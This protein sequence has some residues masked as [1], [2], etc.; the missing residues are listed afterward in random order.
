MLHG[1]T[2]AHLSNLQEDGF[3]KTLLYGPISKDKIKLE[4]I[5]H[6]NLKCACIIGM[7]I[8]GPKIPGFWIWINTL[9]VHHEL[10]V[11]NE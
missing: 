10:W 8:L 2:R 5:T 6:Y 11:R 9:H 7:K 4:N 3:I 1:S